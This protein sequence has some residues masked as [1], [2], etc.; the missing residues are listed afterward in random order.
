MSFEPTC[1]CYINRGLGARIEKWDTLNEAPPDRG[2]RARSLAQTI[3]EEVL[4]IT[5]STERRA[6]HATRGD[7]RKL[8]RAIIA[9]SIGRNIYGCILLH[10]FLPLTGRVHTREVCLCGQWM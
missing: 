2:N 7:D 10:G 4:V 6:M 9:I 8:S 3:K 1:I 5:T